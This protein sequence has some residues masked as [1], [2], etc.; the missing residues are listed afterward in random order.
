MISGHLWGSFVDFGLLEKLLGFFEG[1]LCFNEALFGTLG[2]FWVPSVDFCGPLVDFWGPS[3]E[4]LKPLRE[5]NF[6]VL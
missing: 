4:L 3:V 6:R 1:L 5:G 2:N